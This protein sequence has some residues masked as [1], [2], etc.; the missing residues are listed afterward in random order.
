MKEGIT[1]FHA[2]GIAAWQ[3]VRPTCSSPHKIHIISQNFHLQS[4]SGFLFQLL[5]KWYNHHHGTTRHAASW[6]QV[7]VYKCTQPMVSLLPVTTVVL[8]VD[9]LFSKFPLSASY[10]LLFFFHCLCFP[11]YLFHQLIIQSDVFFLRGKLPRY[12]MNFKKYK[13]STVHLF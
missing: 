13:I 8:K 12:I 1:A 3:W 7:N 5:P 6:A 2:Q 10:I 4:F 11:S 9:Q